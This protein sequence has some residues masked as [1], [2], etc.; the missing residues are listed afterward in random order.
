MSD[1]GTGGKEPEF[2]SSSTHGMEVTGDASQS[3]AEVGAAVEVAGAKLRRERQF[4]P[5][6]QLVRTHV[7]TTEAAFYLSLQAQT[8][9]AWHC[10][11]KGGLAPIKVGKN[12]LWPVSGIR[13]ALGLNCGA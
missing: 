8:L 12:L 13:R 1:A 4:V 7:S 9:R 11:G 5:L 2:G 3:P 6:E 10:Y